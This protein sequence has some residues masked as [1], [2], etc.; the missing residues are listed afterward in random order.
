[1]YSGNK[2]VTD[3]PVN[4][5]ITTPPQVNINP[6]MTP[7]AQPNPAKPDKKELVSKSTIGAVLVG[8]TALAAIGIYI[9]RGGKGKVGPQNVVKTEAAKNLE[10]LRKQADVLQ[11]Q[12]KLEYQKR[13]E[14]H[15]P[16]D[17]F[18]SLL[19][20][21]AFRNGDKTKFGIS[22][23]GEFD[24]VKERLINMGKDY[25]DTSFLYP[26]K[27]AK[28]SSAEKI[29]SE[30][31]KLQEDGDWQSLRKIRSKLLKQRTKENCGDIDTHI[32]LIDDILR[33]KVAKDETIPSVFKEFYGMNIEE[34]TELA[35]STPEIVS[36]K[37]EYHSKAR[38]FES[39]IGPR[40]L[41][42]K[43]FFPK[44]VKSYE[45]ANATI[46]RYNE[47]LKWLDSERAEVKKYEKS[48]SQEFRESENV[49]KLRELNRQINELKKQ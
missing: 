35:K 16:I 39:I 13:V 6:V 36:E 8:L 20:Q 43:D 12:I 38:P 19:V 28:Q 49:K 48:L 29:M 33:S 30:L 42:L 32:C 4:P 45:N 34:A 7:V 9:A 11:E 26:A 5:N 27:R 47:T 22:S 17:R 46:D 10:E 44:D 3:V 37:I 2:G 31:A 23:S 41:V 18:E 24:A 25:S 1:M 21:D 14:E 40:K 15:F